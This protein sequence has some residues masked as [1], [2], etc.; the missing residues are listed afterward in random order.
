MIGQTLGHYRILEKLGE[1]GMGVV[2]RAEDTKLGRMVALKFLPAEISGNPQAIGRLLQEARAASALNHPNICTIFE[3]NEIDGQPFIAMEFLDG[4]SLQ[5]MLHARPLTTEE[6]LRIGAQVADALDAAHAKGVV[7][8]DIK[9][10]NIHVDGR[11]QTKVLDFGL[12]KRVDALEEAE[13]T[14]DAQ[15]TRTVAGTPSYMA[16]EQLRGRPVDARADHHALGAVLYEMVTRQRPFRDEVSANLIDSILNQAPA[17]PRA[18]APRVPAELERIILK[19]LEKDPENRYQT[20]REIAVDLRRL[21]A[22][23]ASS[24]AVPVEK[25]R[26][27]KWA[28]VT[29]GAVVLLLAALFGFNVGGV[30]ERMF[31]GGTSNIRS[32]AVL[33]LENLS[34]NPEEDYFADGMTESLTAELSHISALKVISRTSVMQYK[35]ARTSLPEIAK[36]L[37]V[38]AVIE[39]S[40]MREGN[41]VKITVQL[42]QAPTDT[43][44]WA[45]SYVRE[46]RG[47]LAL[48]S[49]VAQAIAR[50]IR[51]AVT[52]AEAKRFESTRAVDPEAHALTLKGNY[53]INQENTSKEGL[54][55]S[56]E[57]F[58]EA[59][60]KDPG[61][62]PAYVGIA[63]AYNALAGV[64]YLPRLAAAPQINAAIAKSLELD[65]TLGEAYT[66]RADGKFLGEWDWAGAEADYRRALELSPN[67]AYAHNEYAFF[68]TNMKRHEEALSHSARALELDPLSAVIGVN[69]ASYLVNAGQ[70]DQAV[71][72]CKKV[73][74]LY[75]DH[76][77]ASWMLA[78]T[79]TEKK[80]YDQA[81][82]VFLARKVPTAATNWSLGYTYGL[83][84]RKKEAQAVIDYL[85]QKSKRQY[86]WPCIIAVPY[87]GLGD[88]NKAFEWLEKGFQEH[89]YWIAQLQVDRRFDSLRGDPRF[90]DLLR[91]MNFPK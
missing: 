11:G 20:S 42:I 78:V 82:A 27:W 85:V 68:L 40:V 49:E 5:Q 19:C 48:Q 55:K 64:G 61:F 37:N 60:K 12:A 39:G 52:P 32:L 88:K 17:P 70:F 90:Q 91:R 23:S 57:Y 10:G 62:A 1:G 7:H 18:L 51:V 67:S 45:Q 2:Y 21:A 58:Q 3:V 77:F 34:R 38:D 65:P 36:K 16:P 75:P 44:L 87:A 46:M 71:E 28:V 54:E 47:I 4:E 81:I 31:G 53:L 69:R 6:V 56:I 13:L 15:A 86:I 9:P 25:S 59:L 8:R 84:G 76:I 43:H 74:A 30:R 72:Q 50:E 89:D 41:Q 73:L 22:P 63:T 26:G 24:V 66:D 33:P 80:E 83:A 35:G 14:A 29:G 79:L